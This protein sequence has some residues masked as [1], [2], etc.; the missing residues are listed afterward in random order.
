MSTAGR[1]DRGME[2]EFPLSL[3]DKSYD[4]LTVKPAD[5][6]FVS[7]NSKEFIAT[8]NIEL[9]FAVRS[10]KFDPKI[11]FC[12]ENGYHNCYVLE[13]KKNQMEFSVNQHRKIREYAPN[14]HSENEYRYF[15]IVISNGIIQ[16][17]RGHILGNFK[18]IHWEDKTEPFTINKVEPLDG[19]DWKIRFGNHF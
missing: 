18:I 13:I 11:R 6:K 17:G 4:A 14:L 1:G 7:V 2:K 15:W 19:G 12:N 16:I 8:K 10:K 5:E 9:Y 3:M